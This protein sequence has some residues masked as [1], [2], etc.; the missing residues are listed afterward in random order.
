MTPRTDHVAVIIGSGPGIGCHVAKIF[1]SRR[2]NK[3]ALIARNQTQLDKDAE[4]VSSAVVEAGT[5]T[6]G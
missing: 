5:A 2:F 3:V 6:S 1:A 4:A